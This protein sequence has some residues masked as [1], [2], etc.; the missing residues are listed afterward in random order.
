MAD[1]ARLYY[2]FAEFTLE[3]SLWAPMDNELEHKLFEYIRSLR[4]PDTST[5]RGKQYF[6]LFF[7]PDTSC[8]TVRR[9]CCF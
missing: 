9:L 7:L 2:V 1:T 3:H 4:I 6:P 5:R 8:E